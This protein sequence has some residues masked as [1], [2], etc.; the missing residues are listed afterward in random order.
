MTIDGTGG[1]VGLINLEGSKPIELRNLKAFIEED[2]R[3]SHIYQP[4]MI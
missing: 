4:V 3:M 2:M 1:L